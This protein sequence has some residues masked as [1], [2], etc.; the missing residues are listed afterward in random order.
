MKKNSWKKTIL[1]QMEAIGTYKDSF[2]S[3]VEALA[4]I[5]EQRDAALTEFKKSGG[6]ACIIHTMDNG[7]E[8]IKK[9][10]RLQAWQDLNK[11][12]LSY[13]RDL[14]LTP[15]GL[16]KLDEALQKDGGKMSALEKALLKIDGKK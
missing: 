11:D 2:K 3:V 16:K 1:Q 15:A 6:E 14:G 9:N 7:T 8:T 12:A 10:P 4:E 5:L 13:W